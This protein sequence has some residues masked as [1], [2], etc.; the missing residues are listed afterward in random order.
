MGHCPAWC[1]VHLPLKEPPTCLL[2][3]PNT[4]RHTLNH[5]STPKPYKTSISVD[6]MQ[7]INPS[8]ITFAC[9]CISQD[10]LF[11]FIGIVI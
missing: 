10:V 8:F 4:P 3:G 6:V 2:T 9:G 7:Q 5:P 1:L 11:V